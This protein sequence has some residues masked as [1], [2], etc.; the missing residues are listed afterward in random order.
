MPKSKREDQ[1][2]A[3]QGRR[4]AL[5]M[6]GAMLLWLGA[7]ALGRQFGWDPRLAIAFDLAAMA[8]LIWGLWITVQV[9]RARRAERRD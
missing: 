1:R 3:R 6:A 7:L 4:A 5:I 9:Y 8:A 2:L